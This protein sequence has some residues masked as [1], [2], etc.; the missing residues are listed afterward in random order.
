[1]KASGILG[2]Y[3]R[4]T[5]TELTRSGEPVTG[6][7]EQAP[8][9][10]AVRPTPSGRH[11]GTRRRFLTTTA[12]AGIGAAAGL[13]ISFIHEYGVNAIFYDQWDNVALLTHSSFFTTSYSGHTTLGMLWQQHNEN[14]MLFPN[15]LVLALGATTHLNI[16]VELYI[17]AAMALASVALFVISHHRDVPYRALLWYVPVFALALTLGQY[18]DSLFGF[19]IAWFMILLCLAVSLALLDRQK[20]TSI[21]FAVAATAAAIGSFSSL[22]GLL[23]W[24]AGLFV[25]WWRRHPRRSVLA[26]FGLAAVTT[27]LYFSGT[28]RVSVGH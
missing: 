10:Y 2:A 7:V 16:L 18:G 17:S 14:R 27:F 20:L 8:P 26:W 1:M 24:P 23:I 9:A 25:L 4:R 19:Q 5:M 22:Q 12:L 28:P 13:Y 21:S 15:L 6:R 11:M 3:R